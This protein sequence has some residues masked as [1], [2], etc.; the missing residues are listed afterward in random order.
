MKIKRLLS[1]TSV[2]AMMFNS[3]VVFAEES[4]MINFKYKFK[5]DGVIITGLISDNTDN[6]TTLELPDKIT[7]DSK[8]Y[9]IIGVENLAFSDLENLTS[10]YL[11]DSLKVDYTGDIAFLTETS[12]MTYLEE[13]IGKDYTETDFL[14]YVA[15]MLEYNG[16]TTGWTEDEL[17]EILEKLIYKSELAGATDEMD[18]EDVFMLMIKNKELLQLTDT[19]MD[20][21]NLW[22]STIKYYD[23]TLFANENTEA[24]KYVKSK[25]FLGLKYSVPSPTDTALIGDA[26]LDGKVNVRDCSA[27]AQALALGKGSVLPA[28]SDYN[29]DGAINIR[30]A[31]ALAY[32]LAS[33]N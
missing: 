23:L 20:K 29:T 21:F 14:E 33:G 11:P 10:V 26:N 24:A 7:Y 2:I 31:A 32:N 13:V 15:E 6:I 8:D 25:E 12:V 5:N 18:I 1:L 16:K 9:D 17:N 28:N 3:A 22:I 30:D 19:N 4:D 27:I